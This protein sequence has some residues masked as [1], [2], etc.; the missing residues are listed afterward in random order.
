VTPSS[1]SPPGG[2][3]R[4]QSGPRDLGKTFVTGHFT[5]QASRLRPPS[6]GYELLAKVC[7]RHTV[8]SD[9]TVRVSSDPW[10]VVVNDERVRASGSA[11]SYRTVHLHRGQCNSGWLAFQTPAG[12]IEEIRYANSLNERAIWGLFG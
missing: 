1:E 10:T 7:V 6:D 9:P 4:S 5:V 12:A 11:G 8:A 2:E 3:P